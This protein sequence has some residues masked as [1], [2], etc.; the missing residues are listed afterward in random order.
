METHTTGFFEP[1]R[2]SGAGHPG[3]RTSMNGMLNL[4]YLFWPAARP[5]PRTSQSSS[6]MA[7]TNV[8]DVCV[9]GAAIDWFVT[10]NTYPR[11][12]NQGYPAARSVRAPTAS[13]L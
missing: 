10:F 4:M 5:S 6:Y 8:R 13:N 11:I 12:R 2:S 3:A 1:D 9:P 7:R